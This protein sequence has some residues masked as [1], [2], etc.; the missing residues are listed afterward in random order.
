MYEK[1]VRIIEV[2]DGYAVFLVPNDDIDIEILI[3]ALRKT[4]E[5]FHNRCIHIHGSWYNSG[6]YMK[7]LFSEGPN[8]FSQKKRVFDAKTVQLVRALVCFYITEI[9]SNIKKQEIFMEWEWQ[10]WNDPK[11]ID[12]LLG[13]LNDSN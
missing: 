12:N 2:D 6:H 1:N 4:A 9:L 10:N 8:I 13:Y 3:E 5:D 11:V 7:I